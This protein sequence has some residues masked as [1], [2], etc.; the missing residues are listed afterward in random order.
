M[1]EQKF[2]L[3]VTTNLDYI[4][5]KRPVQIFPTEHP[6]LNAL[7]HEYLRLLD[8]ERELAKK[9]ADQL[10][11]DALKEAIALLKEELAAERI[12]EAQK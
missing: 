5:E 6:E 9:R 11:A 7:R 10:E 3:H 4:K 12:V 8:V 2:Y 1:S